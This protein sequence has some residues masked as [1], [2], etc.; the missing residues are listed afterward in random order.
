MVVCHKLSGHP[1]GTFLPSFEMPLCHVPC[2]AGA[3]ESVNA[4]SVTLDD[5]V[6]GDVLLM[7]VDVE[8][9]EWGVMKGAAKLLKGSH[10]I[11]NIIMEYSPGGRHAS[12]PSTRLKDGKPA[13]SSTAH[14]YR[15]GKRHMGCN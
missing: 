15:A 5:T 8:G 10:A 7:K 4:T 1:S 2:G 11:D 6:K 12:R 3:Y 13:R 14:R 9:W